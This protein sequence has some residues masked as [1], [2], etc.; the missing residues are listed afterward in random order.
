[1]EKN[2]LTLASPIEGEGTAAPRST[3]RVP[4]GERPRLSSP[5]WIPASAGMTVRHRNDGWT[6]VSVKDSREGLR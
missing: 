2:T 5:L 4:Q 6:R 1:M 3:L